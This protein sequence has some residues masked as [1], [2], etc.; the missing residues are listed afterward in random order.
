M[1]YQVSFHTKTSYLHVKIT[2]KLSLVHVERSPLLWL[3]GA[4]SLLQHKKKD[5]NFSEMVRY[6]I[7][8]LLKHYMAAQNS[9]RNFVSPRG[10]V[11]SSISPTGSGHGW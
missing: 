8:V 9:K 5:I 2:V 1:K 6:F 11:I 3:H 10:H 4:L 7:G